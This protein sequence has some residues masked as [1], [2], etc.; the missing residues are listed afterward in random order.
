MMNVTS[1]GAMP[2][3]IDGVLVARTVRESFRRAKR[4]PR[5]SLSVRFVSPREI[6]ALNARYRKKKRPTDVLSFSPV[7]GSF[8]HPSTRREGFEWGDIVVCPDIARREAKRR[9]I[10]PAEELVRLVSHGTLHLLGYD[11]A[12]AAEEERMFSI[13]EHVVE[14]ITSRL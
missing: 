13:Q 8:P 6:T 7:E 11:H 1:S 3:E 9:G 5:G 4:M 12:T 2:R 10:L 14:R